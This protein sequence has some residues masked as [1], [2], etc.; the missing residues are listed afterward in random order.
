MTET[1]LITGGAGFIASHLA[2]DA[3][4]AGHR[5]VV[6]DNLSS[7]RRENVPAGAELVVRDLRE[8]GVEEVL[9]HYRVTAVSHHAAQA[10][11]RVSVDDLLLDAEA[12]VIGSL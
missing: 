8:D 5:V 7:G 3:L 2:D 10:N 9:A 1:L 4:Q 6:L 11:V 12:I